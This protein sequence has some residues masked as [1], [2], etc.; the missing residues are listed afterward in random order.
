MSRLR[1]AV[2]LGAILS[3]CALLAAGCGINSGPVRPQAKAGEADA[4]GTGIPL[5]D[6][7]K[8]SKQTNVP[9]DLVMDFL[10]AAADDASSRLQT[11]NSY[12]VPGEYWNPSKEIHVV[13]VLEGPKASSNFDGSTLVQLRVQHVGSLNA[14]GQI[15][16]PTRGEE[17]LAFTV[18]SQGEQGLYLAR[19]PQEMLM[20]ES[21]L[22]NNYFETRA[23]Y[24][25]DKSGRGLIPD[26]RYVHKH[27]LEEAKADLLVKWLYEGP[28]AWLRPTVKELPPDTRPPVGKK[29]TRD[30]SGSLFVDLATAPAGEEFDDMAKQ[31]AKTLISG[32]VASL[33]L[34]VQGQPQRELHRPQEELRPAP[35]R[36]GL[37]NGSVRRLDGALAVTSALSLPDG[38][39]TNLAAVAFDGDESRAVLVHNDPDAKRVSLWTREGGLVPIQLPVSRPKRVLQPVW[40]DASAALVVMDSKLYQLGFD[41]RAVPVLNGDNLTAISV[42]AEDCRVALVRNGQL[43]MAALVR[44]PNGIVSI[45]P[46]PQ[47]VPTMFVNGVQNVAFSGRPTELIV[48]GADSKS[49]TL[50]SMNIDGAS[51]SAYRD[52]PFPLQARVSH[53]VAW[54]WGPPGALFEVEGIR[55]YEAQFS[56]WVPLGG[57]EASPSPGGETKVTAPSF[58]D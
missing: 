54:P 3:L 7:L 21:A 43:M 45:G 22:S 20:L 56:R 49:V 28:V 48:A 31:L 14:S 18:V 58:G 15:E 52:D 2:I 40:L 26:L 50:A 1:G 44:A 57:P 39:N 12:L 11:M 23:L 41:G 10:T 47:V 38:L 42:G 37:V 9:V 27:L 8:R 33:H 24:F 4:Q 34:L 29:V 17:P 25:Q 13:R 46:E 6:K 53:L 55:A 35:R 51:Y 19:P 32:D 30:E 16:S 5:R 36:Y